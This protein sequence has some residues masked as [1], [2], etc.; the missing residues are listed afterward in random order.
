M[1]KIF[2]AL[3]LLLAVIWLTGCVG[4]GGE[5]L[6]LAHNQLNPSEQQFSGTLHLQKSAN[7]LREKQY[8][9]GRATITLFAITS[10]SVKTSSD[11]KLQITEQ[12][13]HALES[14]GY[15]VNLIDEIKHSARNNKVLITPFNLQ[16]FI[17][18]SPQGVRNA[19]QR[20]SIINSAIVKVNIK[21]FFFKNYNWFWPIV[22]TWGEIELGLTV[23]RHNGDIVFNKSFSGQGSSSCLLGQCAFNTA[24][25]EAVTDVLNK[26]IQE[27][28]NEEFQTAISGTK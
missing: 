15:Q 14:M 20:D 26:I 25:T 13:M 1:S 4:I 19:A 27:C 22:P 12:V 18:P 17:Q 28:S 11:V 23:E 2:T 6:S 5:R 10:G 21:E 9:I 16:D 7:D 24:V 8:R 3:A